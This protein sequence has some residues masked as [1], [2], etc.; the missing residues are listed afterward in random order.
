MEILPP[1]DVQQKFDALSFSP[2]LSPSFYTHSALAPGVL[3]PTASTIVQRKIH[4]RATC[5]KTIGFNQVH[6]LLLIM[7]ISFGTFGRFRPLEILS[8]VTT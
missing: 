5:N 7:A 8:L 1:C 3:L 4:L 6:V 2:I